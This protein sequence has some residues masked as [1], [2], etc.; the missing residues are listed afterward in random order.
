MKLQ[1]KVWNI[2]DDWQ[3]MVATTME[4]A[5]SELLGKMP[6]S[7]EAQVKNVETGEIFNWKPPKNTINFGP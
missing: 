6:Y 3:D 5:N 7:E 1:W 2:H 4:Q